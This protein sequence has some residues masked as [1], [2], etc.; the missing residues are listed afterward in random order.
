MAQASARALADGSVWWQQLAEAGGAQPLESIA[1]GYLSAAHRDAP[2]Q[3]CLAAALGADA[4][5][6][7]GPV[8]RAVTAGISAMVEILAQWM[9]GRS[10]AA[11]REK[12]LALYASMVGAVVLARAVD[13]AALSEEILQSVLR[14]LPAPR[15]H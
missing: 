14:T 7:A 13:D 5:R 8:R 10:K 12:A 4:A 15:T 9:P 3:G 2:G 1:R 11:Q 6:Q